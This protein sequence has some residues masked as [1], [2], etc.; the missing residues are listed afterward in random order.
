MTKK[1]ICYCI[2]VAVI[3]F[4]ICSL[5]G[6]LNW[7]NQLMIVPVTSALT[8]AFVFKTISQKW[9]ARTIVI[10]PFYL[11]YIIISI[12]AKSEPTYPIWILGILISIFS[13]L[14]FVLNFRDILILP[15]AIAVTIAVR[16][17]FMPSYF[18]HLSTDKYLSKYKLDYISFVDSNGNEIN[19]AK[20]KGKVLL[21][22][23]WANTCLP[24]IEKFPDLEAIQDQYSLDTSIKIFAVNIP[25][26]NTKE[27]QKTSIQL[28]NKFRFENIYLKNKEESKKIFISKIPTILIFDKSGQCVFAGSLNYG[29]NIFIDNTIK[30]L[31]NAKL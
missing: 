18:A 5:G 2:L 15:I 29:I 1:Q 11:I 9:Y 21:L 20:F 8:I 30:I 26:D 13:I 27:S 14:A 4:S 28:S 22:D 24:C 7:F 10:F 31:N 16:F 17:L 25:L 23:I 3:H 19:M 12:S 6:A